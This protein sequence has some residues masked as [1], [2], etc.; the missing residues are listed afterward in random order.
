MIVYR[1][2]LKITGTDAINDVLTVV[3]NSVNVNLWIIMGVEMKTCR[4]IEI[5]KKTDVDFI[6]CFQ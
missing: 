3:C 1:Y 6:E 2:L 4:L 5:Y